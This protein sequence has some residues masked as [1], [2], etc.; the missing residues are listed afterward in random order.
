MQGPQCCICHQYCFLA[1]AV[2]DTCDGAGRGDSGDGGLGGGGGGSG[3]LG[4]GRRRNARRRRFA[5]G[6][7]L[8]ELC[9][10]PT[11][12]YTYYRRKTAG[13]LRAAA[14]GLSSL[15]EH[16]EEW[17]NEARG[18]LTA[19]RGRGGRRGTVGA[20]VTAPSAGC[21][22]V[23]SSCDGS[24]RGNFS[25]A[26]K[27]E[28]DNDEVMVVKVEEVV[29]AAGMEKGENSAVASV[30]AS[31]SNTTAVASA[32]DTSILAPKFSVKSKGEGGENA[33]VAVAVVAGTPLTGKGID[34]KA[35][36]KGGASCTLP[37]TVDGAAAGAAASTRVSTSCAAG[38]S[39]PAPN[40]CCFSPSTVSASFSPLLP[41]M[42][43][44][45]P[46]LSYLK[47]LIT[48]GEDLGGPDGVLADLRTLMESCA[49]WS[50][51]VENMLGPS[52]VIATSP[53]MLL[54]SSSISSSSSNA[55]AVSC[56]GGGTKRGAV[57]ASLPPPQSTGG[58]ER[59]VVG[60]TGRDK[61]KG[62]SGSG[63]GG[64]SPRSP[65]LRE[66]IP[67]HKAAT[68]LAREAGLPGRPVE[69]TDRLC[70]AVL[71]SCRLGVQVRSLLG[72]DEDEVRRIGF[73]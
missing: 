50:K 17:A 27:G 67:F 47:E 69:S 45:R 56:G 37:G 25:V 36:V 73:G 15:E 1:V 31:A 18:V 63:S 51:A 16:R 13:E 43:H 6:R 10:C 53:A 62:V 60:G 46:T 71:A 35:Y 40:L 14:K 52:D 38:F 3:A 42:W 61:G 66:P 12:E 24:N 65:K 72:L 29:T 19:I 58:F 70:S 39:Q 49:R 59:L 2:C 48:A 41:P 64:S 55:A 33:G 68:L 28:E 9:A 30:S 5:C 26:V 34:H 57:G 22:G 4:G 21:D 23:L 8:E 7:H 20:S 54:S 11:S 32:A 44:E